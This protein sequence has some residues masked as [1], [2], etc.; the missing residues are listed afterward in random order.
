MFRHSDL[1]RAAAYTFATSMLNAT[2][3]QAELSPIGELFK[4]YSTR[5]G[6]IPVK[7]SGS[8]PQPAPKWPVGGEQPRV[9]AG[10]DTY[11]I[12]VVAAWDEGH[13]ALSIAVV[14]P[15]EARQAMKLS[16]EGADL[17]HKATLL[18]LAHSDINYAV[19][20]GERSQV[21]VQ[22]QSVRNIASEQTLPPYSVS[23]YLVSKQ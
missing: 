5:F 22:Q 12:D 15:T 7:V 14:N 3:N 16:I 19:K 1:F 11:P 8:S 10:S 17:A 4:L 6:S 2:R 18:R 20:P 21:K 23:V 13:K 9:N